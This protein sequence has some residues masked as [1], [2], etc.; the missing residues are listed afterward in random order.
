[1]SGISLERNPVVQ[2]R[3]GR[4]KATLHQDVREGVMTPPITIGKRWSAW[5]SDEVDAVVRARIAGAS[6][7]A[8]RELVK[9]LVARRQTAAPIQGRIAGVGGDDRHV[10]IGS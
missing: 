5:P 10:S 1:M 3:M 8:L 9:E 7:D 4:G 6:K 2:K